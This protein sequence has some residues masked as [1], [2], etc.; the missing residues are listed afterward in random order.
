MLVFVGLGLY[1]HRDVSIRG[2]EAISHAD[3]VFFEGYTSRLVGTSLEDMEE[4][5]GKEMN[6]SQEGGCR[7]RSRND[8][9]S[10]RIEECRFL[11]RWRS[12]DFHDT[13]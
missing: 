12:H 11:D 13:C 3:M 8:P 6:D 5:F 7:K 4:Y 10:G 2:F 9:R 1:D